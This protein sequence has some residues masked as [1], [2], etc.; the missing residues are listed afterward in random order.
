[1]QNYQDRM[2]ALLGIAATKE[3]QHQP[4]P[5]ENIMSAFIEDRV[6]FETR[7]M[8]LSHLNRCEICYL[9][10]EQLNIHV[11]Q[12]Q[13]YT[14]RLHNAG[15]HQRSRNGFN[16]DFSWRKVFPGLVFVSLLIALVVNIL[17]T[18]YK[19]IDV[20]TPMASAA[21]LDAGTL[22]TSINQ[23]PVP[24]N[25]QPFELNDSTYAHPVKAFGVGIW[26]A[27][28]ALM[29]EAD[30]IPTLLVSH[31]TIDW[32]ASQWRDYYTLGQL[33]LDAWVLANAKQIKPTQW[34]LL[35]Q[36]LQALETG[37]QERLQ[38]EPEASIALQLIDKMKINLKRLSRKTDYSARKS[39]LNEIEIGLEKLFE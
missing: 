15:Y 10:W 27:R 3:V 23:L 9:T 39:L 19:E 20:D 35:R 11:A 21:I 13:P 14:R 30:S 4:C 33:T 1:M 8:I 17:V 5:S 12:S 38:S 31:P 18:S 6:D 16:S 24:W 36:S 2:I 32:Q 26:S 37:L 25:N 22:A 34:T 7:A 29:N 28:N